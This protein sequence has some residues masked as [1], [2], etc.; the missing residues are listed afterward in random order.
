MR[1]NTF[2]P[3]AIVLFERRNMCILDCFTY[4]VTFSFRRF[5]VCA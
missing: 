3:N 2:V 5:Y 1:L 4:N